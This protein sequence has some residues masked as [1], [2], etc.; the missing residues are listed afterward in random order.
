MTDCLHT[1][2]YN[3]H[4]FFL[5]HVHFCLAFSQKYN[6][7][8]NLLVVYFFFNTQCLQCFMTKMIFFEKQHTCHTG[9]KANLNAGYIR[10][11]KM[12]KMIALQ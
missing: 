3:V 9:K 12:G 8:I 2:L 7:E 10:N 11:Q 1:C 6:D 4:S 5:A